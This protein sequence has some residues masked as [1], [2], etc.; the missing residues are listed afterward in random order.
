MGLGQE[1][2]PLSYAVIGA[3]LEVQR[4]L[5]GGFLEAVY[6]HAV[7]R[8]LKA[9]GIEHEQEAGL[10]IHYKGEPLPI[11]YRADFLCGPERGLLVE[12]KAQASTGAVEEAQVI[13][14]LK[15]TGLNVAILANFG[16]RRLDFRRF[17][18]ARD[19]SGNDVVDVTAI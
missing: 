8:E 11:V 17:V 5:G 4:T 19:E 16:P 2:S 1:Q 10:T 13:N 3:L 12:L 14:Y 9:R 15:A 18:R 7:A 6:Q